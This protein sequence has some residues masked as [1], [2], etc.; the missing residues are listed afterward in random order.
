MLRLRLAKTSTIR[1]DQLVVE[2]R[3]DR[4]RAEHV[5]KEANRVVNTTAGATLILVLLAEAKNLAVLR[6]LPAIAVPVEAVLVA[7]LETADL[8]ELLRQTVVCDT[9]FPGVSISGHLLE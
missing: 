1:L 4:A 3:V 9:L 2:T 7:G 5:R 8:E 6:E